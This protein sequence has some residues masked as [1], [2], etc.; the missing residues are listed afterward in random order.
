MYQRSK[1][2]IILENLPL[3]KKIAGAIYR[4]I[5]EGVVEFD[6]LVNTGVIGLIKALDK[7]DEKRSKFSTYAYIKIRGEILDYLRRLDPLPRNLREKIKNSDWEDYKEEVL[8]FISLEGE[9]FNGSENLRVKDTLQGDTPNP[10]EVVLRQELIELLS[11]AISEL[12]EREQ[13][14][15]QLLFV[16]ELDLKSV[17]EILGISVSR[18][19]QLKAEALKKLREI[20][21]SLV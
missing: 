14:V 17:S 3:V 19:S 9:L 1:K 6:E 18:V 11:K 2:E 13:L 4:R 8:F 16:E 21:K 5:P 15:L 7:Y 10:E 12:P 20:F